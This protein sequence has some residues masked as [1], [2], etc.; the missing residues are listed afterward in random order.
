MKF[1]KDSCSH[2]LFQWASK[3]GWH[4]APEGL[5]KPVVFVFERK[6]WLAPTPEQIA[7]YRVSRRIVEQLGGSMN[8]QEHEIAG[9]AELLS[10]KDVRDILRAVR[11]DNPNA[12]VIDHWNGEGCYTM[13][14]GV[15]LGGK[16]Q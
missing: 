1:S 10:A 7:E 9:K 3:G 8:K 5:A 15:D 6:S 16:A 12:K 2:P 4:Q 13:S 11:R 14:V